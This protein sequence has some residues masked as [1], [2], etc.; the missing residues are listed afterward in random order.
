MKQ[1]IT[2]SKQDESRK[3]PAILAGIFLF[4]LLLC[5]LIFH[6]LYTPMVTKAPA[7]F[8]LIIEA[9]SQSGYNKAGEITLFRLLALLGCLLVGGG[10][11]MVCRKTDHIQQ[12][13]NDAKYTENAAK[14]VDE[15]A[16]RP[17]D[18][19]RS[20]YQ[21]YLPILLLLLGLFY[22]AVS[23]VF[24]LPL[25][26]MA[27]YAAIML[28]VAGQKDY[29]YVC[30]LPVLCYYGLLGIFMLLSC[31]LQGVTLSQN[32]LYLLVIAATA[33]CLL[34][35]WLKEKRGGG[36]K[37]ASAS[38]FRRL[39]FIQ[40]FPVPLLLTIYLKDH[41]R[42]EGELIR[43]PYAAGYYVMIVLLL[44]GLYAWLFLSVK[45]KQAI[46]SAVT[47]MVLFAYRSWQACPA[48]AQPDQHHHGEQLIPWQQIVT[49]GQSAYDEYTPVSGLF[50]MVN[51]FIQHVFLGGTVADYAP[52]LSLTTLFFAILTMGLVCRHVKPEKAIL[53]A[54]VFSLPSYNRQYMVAPLLLLFF[55]PAL[56]KRPS[57]WLKTWLFGCFLGGLYYPLF[58]A[59]VL[60]GTLPMAVSQLFRLGKGSIIGGNVSGSVASQTGTE[61]SVAENKNESA[62]HKKEKQNGRAVDILTWLVVLIPIALCLPLLCRMA[63]HTLTYSSQ[64]ILADGISLAGQMPPDTFLPYLTGTSAEGLRGS[65]YLICRFFLPMAWLWFGA[66]LLAGQIACGGVLRPG[67]RQDNAAENELAHGTSRDLQVRFHFAFAL[68]AVLAVSYTY[69]L[70]RADSQVILARTAPVLI[71][72]GGLFAGVMLLEHF[73]ADKTLGTA[74]TSAAAFLFVLCMGLPFLC[75]AHVNDM[76]NPY[77]WTYPDGNEQLVASD[78]SRLFTFYEVPETFVFMGEISL[79]DQSM[80]GNGFM[81][82]DQVPYLTQYDRVK[83]RIAGAFADTEGGAQKAYDQT[84]MG[85][86]GQGFYYYMGTKA[87]AAGYL[88]V[89]RSRQAQLRILD[90]AVKERPVVFSLD[91]QKSFYIWRWLLSDEADYRYLAEDD[92]F[93]PAE[94]YEKMAAR[95]A[96]LPKAGDDPADTFADLDLARNCQSFG[97]SAELLLKNLAGGVTGNEVSSKADASGDAANKTDG[98]DGFAD[99]SGL[100]AF[101][102]RD[103]ELLYLSMNM[104][105]LEAT[106]GTRPVKLA[107]IFFDTQG[108]E[109]QVSCDMGSGRLL[110]PMGMHLRWQTGQIRDLV[111][112]ISDENGNSLQLDAKQLGNFLA[113]QD[114]QSGLYRVAD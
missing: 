23:G 96:S 4:V 44:I 114:L 77:L 31:F 68:L 67:A 89:A 8:D 12:T 103:Y 22:L 28:P 90:V 26:F 49:L 39:L 15:A 1:N 25:F 40:Q 56:L 81:V 111:F 64:T 58:G 48:F 41:Y 55:D 109:G 95:D 75:Y 73:L 51:G 32:A 42:Y 24:S 65:L 59:A 19:N 2:P 113:D 85:Y 63:V 94:I 110:V 17:A 52:A 79:S 61:E 27:G 43:G 100:Q 66:A 80:L 9:T 20:G 62:D 91:P 37:A 34:F 112:I 76:K 88:P 57:A 83:L 72:V 35:Y 86:D 5:I 11:F 87:C 30:L 69:T 29:P 3:A 16:G 82:E 70:V 33:L 104:E 106:L 60:V 53:F 18:E 99:L 74:K 84:Y 36:E 38:A 47:P 13:G 93:Y 98:S 21:K 105:K 92:A 78:A 10:T 6:V 97:E 54:A 102:G 50:P 14:A 108:K 101:R 7:F 46:I 45:K 107:V 71:A